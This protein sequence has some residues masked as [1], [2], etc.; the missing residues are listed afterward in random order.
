MRDRIL[1]ILNIK[2]SE[3]RYIFDLLRIQLFIGIAHSL[4]NIV[5]FTYFIYDFKIT[6]LPYAYLAIA[7]GLLL[8]NVVYQKLEHKFTPLQ[9]LK[10]IIAFSAFLVFFFWTGLFWNKYTLVFLLLVWGTL[11]YMITG[12]AYWGIVSLL[13]N[14]RESKRVFSIVGSGDIPAKL[15]GY[16]SAPLLISAL[17]LQNLLL[18]SV[19]T[20][21]FGYYQLHKLIQKKRWDSFKTRSNNHYHSHSLPQSNNW[22]VSFFKHKLIFAISI[23]S[24]LSYNVFN[25][26]DYTFISQIKIRFHDLSILASFVATFFAIGRV[27]AFFLKLI[28]TSRLIE[29]IGIIQCLLITP[30]FLFLF[31][32]IFFAFNWVYDYGLYIFGFMA[33]FTEVLRS[34]IQE[35]V[36]F[37]LFQPLNEQNRLHGHIIAKG[38]ML[39]PS[40]FIVG[41]SL[42]LFKAFGVQLTLLFTIE[43]LLINLFIWATIIYFLRKSYLQTLHD[44]IAKGVFSG[45]SIYIFDQKSIDLLLDKVVNGSESEVIYALKLLENASYEKMDDVLAKQLY[46]PQN[47]IRQYALNRLDEKNKLSPSTLKDLLSEETDVA[48][49]E[50][51]IS[52]LCKRDLPY[53]KSISEHISDQDYS[54][55]KNIIIH[56]LNHNEFSYLLKA[57]KEIDNLI[58][59]PHAKERELALNIISELN[60]IQFTETI[61]EM[62]GDSEPSVK[63]NAILVACKLRIKKLLPFLFSLLNNPVDKYLVLQGFMQYGD[64]LFKDIKNL[65]PQEVDEHI[66]SLIKIASHVKGSNSINF[67][68]AAIGKGYN[69]KIVHAFWS[70]G[71]EAQTVPDIQ[72]F[73]G[74]LNLYLKGGIDKINYY[75]RVPSFRY[76]DLVKSSIASE[77]RNDLFN[78]LKICAILYHKKE[79]NRVIELLEHEEKSRIYNAM[80]MLELVLPKR[81][82]RQINLLLDFTLDPSYVKKPV[83]EQ[84]STSFFQKIVNTHSTV[85]NSW[86]KAICIYCSLKNN[87]LGFIQGLSSYN[88]AKENVILRETRN[89]AL[90]AL[91]ESG[92]ANY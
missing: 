27:C 34:T 4:I 46:S 3:S 29:K 56:L 60:R 10:L 90:K 55:R 87:N 5:A 9:L 12:Y 20:L 43:V 33:I 70:K 1:G 77:I 14:I 16:L 92:Y 72:T 2:V 53:L 7:A 41:L 32:L 48:V 13:F 37:A 74:L 59:S 69:D 84:D 81:T 80:E 45:D 50:K 17:G 86:T 64:D 62:I 91:Q 66:S 82:S 36:F 47:A 15:I 54:I 26:I 42:I 76:N 51:L 35:P 40:L 68:F 28:F 88:D 71:F 23:L 19:S 18:L 30:S 44:S 73:Q 8:S 79:I 83:S 57:G 31:C 24:I 38:Y 52:I 61:E 89:Y 39:A 85:F 49:K 63:R 21:I 75:S 67:L 65:P 6:G 11:F 78:S 22:I 58:K 25:L